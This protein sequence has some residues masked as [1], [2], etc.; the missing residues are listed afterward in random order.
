MMEYASQHS[1]RASGLKSM[2]HSYPSRGS[3][4]RYML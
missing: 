4:I 1:I 3:D 2:P